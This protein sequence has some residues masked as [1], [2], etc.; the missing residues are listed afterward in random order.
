MTQTYGKIVVIGAGIAGLCTAVYAQSCGYQIEIVEQ[1]NTAGGLATSWRRGDYTFETC[2]HWLVGSS[3]HGTMH[4]QWQEV[5]DIDKLTFVYPEEFVRLEDEKGESLSIYANV[6]RL[7]A[8]LLQ[9][10]PQDA[11]EIRRLTSAIRR[12]AKFPIP[13]PSEPWPRRARALLRVLPD[14][15][16]LRK[17]SRLSIQEYGKRFTHELLRNFFGNG[18]MGRLSALALVFS[19]A[20]M[21]ER[22]AGYAVG[23][24][25]GIVRLI[26]ARLDQLGGR[27]RLGAKVE[28]ILVEHDA[29]VGVQLTGGETIAADW[30]I[31]AAD[32]RATIY[33]MLG[34]KYADPRTDKRYDTD[35]METFPSYVQVSLGVARDLSGQAGYVTRVL[36][37][38]L[39]LTPTPSLGGSRSAS[40][41]STRPSRRRERPPSP[42]FCR[43]AISL[44]GPIYNA[45]TRRVTRRKSAGSK[46]RLSR[47]SKRWCR[48]S[49]M[50]S[51]WLMCRPRPPSFATRITGKAAWR[52]GC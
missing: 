49:A 28:K 29:A 46:R 25:Q 15:P 52:V 11:V 2:L 40:F 27:L 10:A 41:I 5:F 51:K 30:V 8:E 18:E 12:F 42:V 3:P 13:D 17:W 33:D 43:R 31:S 32:G 14:L 19:L 39:R 36:E 9:R 21:S 24:S 6:D 34:G 7:E 20:W 23:G 26:R 37:R 48:T 44:S 45:M 16:L 35:T 4:A 50:R 1:H 47:F 38:P 22:N